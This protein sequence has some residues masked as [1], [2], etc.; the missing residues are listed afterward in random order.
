MI[1]RERDRARGL[2]I[3]TAHVLHECVR[4]RVDVPDP[5]GN[6]VDVGSGAPAVIDDDG[7]RHGELEVRQTI[8]ARFDLDESRRRDDQRHD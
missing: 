4:E 6:L 3:D 2:V 8:Y 1:G 7:D 5:Q